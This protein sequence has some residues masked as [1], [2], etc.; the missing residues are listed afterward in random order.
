MISPPNIVIVIQARTGSTRFP[1]KILQPILGSPVLSL[2]I[3]RVQRSKFSDGLVI[4]TTNESTDDVIVK[5]CEKENVCCYRGHSTDLL[6]RHYQASFKRNA[7]IVVKIPSDCPLIDP[8]IIDKVIDYYLENR[9]AYDYVSNLHPATY[10]DGNDV[11]VFPFNILQTAWKEASKNFEREHT[12]PF[13]WDNPERF[14]I[15]NVTWET[16][17]D[18]S[19]THRLV[20]DFPADYELI[21]AVYE[22]LYPD[23]PQ[24][25]LND[26]IALLDR[27]Q[28][29][30]ALNSKYAGVNWYRLH[31]NELKTINSDSTNLISG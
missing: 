9:S 27:R 20:L 14:R 28:D 1:N 8:D 25:A 11:E 15:G 24:F 26:I 7:D 30:K 13:V 19:M 31:I 5:L 3:E 2:M 29:I 23:N 12:T 22:E 18:Y 16:G 4:A 21:K 10:P 6:G 17:L